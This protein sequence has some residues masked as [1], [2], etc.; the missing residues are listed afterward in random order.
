MSAIQDVDQPSLNTLDRHRLS[1]LLGRG[2][3]AEVFLAAWHV[4]PD[5]VRPVVVKRLYGHFSEDPTLVRMFIDEARLVCQLSHENIV[6]TYEVG[7][8]E[9]H[10]C[11]AMEYLEG[12]DAATASPPCM[13]AR[14]LSN[15]TRRI[16]CR[17][18]SA[19]IEVCT[20]R[21]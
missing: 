4:A 2:G 8:I 6:K 7:L 9:G 14:K 15:L 10:L 1:C 20:R 11:I 5:V 13:G 21:D 17:L 12:Q 3:M 19:C 16:R 18:R